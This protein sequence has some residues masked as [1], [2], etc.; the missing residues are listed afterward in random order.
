MATSCVD[1]VSTGRVARPDCVPATAPPGAVETMSTTS[2][3]DRK[4]RRLLGKALPVVIR[5]ETE[6]RR[7]MKAAG[8]PIERPEGAKPVQNRGQTERLSP[9]DSRSRLDHWLPAGALAGCHLPTPRTH[10]P[11]PRG[12]HPT[13]R[14]A[15]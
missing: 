2:I 9:A 11:G 10:R 13:A 6:Y 4:Y 15:R 14:P 3:D 12:G 7:L 8:V 1:R 5:S